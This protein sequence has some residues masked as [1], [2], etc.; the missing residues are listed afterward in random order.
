MATIF[1]LLIYLAFISLGL[2]DTLLGSLWPVMQPELGVPLDAMGL[3]S[4]VV[5]VAT[6]VSSLLCE[7]VVRLLGTSKVTALSGVLTAAA[8]LGYA[9]SATFG[10]LVLFAVPLGLGAG[11]VDT[12]LN[13]YAALHL[14]ARHLN[15]LH[16]FWGIGAAA[17]PAILALIIQ[18]GR[19]W[20]SGYLVIALIQFAIAAVLLFTLPIWKGRDYKGA[21]L[22]RRNEAGQMP[23]PREK[24]RPLLRIPGVA[25]ALAAFAVCVSIDLGTGMWVPSYLVE[26]RQFTPEMGAQIS[27][28]FYACVTIG[29]FLSGALAEKWSNKTLIRLGGALCICGA[30][31][32]CLPLPAFAYYIFI[33]VAGLGCAPIFPAMIHLT[34]TR[35]GRGESPRIMG[36]QMAASYAGQLAISP[37][38][39]FVAARAGILAI[40]LMLLG[41]SVAIL[42]FSEAADRAVAKHPPP[43]EVPKAGPAP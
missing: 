21:P 32:L 16:C 8:L 3:V 33:A 6:V 27:A 30:L 36:V 37:C 28:V 35:F 15:W 38:I 26:A 40:P 12:C 13:N 14:S 2:P 39:G 17:G 20:R 11:A 22:K 5:S 34:P 18:N 41:L 42:L 10:W 31:L 43:A 4:I 25:W 24:R 29:R 19:G 1:L 23:S 7:R 9:Q